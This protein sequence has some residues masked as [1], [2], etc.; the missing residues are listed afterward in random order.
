M[1]YE[2]FYWKQPL[3]KMADRIEKYAVRGEL[4]ARQAAQ[5]ERDMFLGFYT[6]RKLFK[7]ASGRSIGALFWHGCPARG[8]PDPVQ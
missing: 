4:T 8:Q 5:C 3:L 2:S 1:F 6:V 7:S